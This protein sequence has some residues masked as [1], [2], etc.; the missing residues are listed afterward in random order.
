MHYQRAEDHPVP[1]NVRQPL[2]GCRCTCERIK[3]GAASW[4]YVY[5]VE[6]GCR[7]HARRVG[8][9]GP[10]TTEWIAAR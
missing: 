8:R 6:P 7:A 9:R 2:A 1:L 10:G 4:K 3:T 5:R